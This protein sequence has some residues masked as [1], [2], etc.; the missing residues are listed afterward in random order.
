MKKL[1]ITFHHRRFLRNI[2]IYTL[3]CSL[4]GFVVGVVVG[5]LTVNVEASCEPIF[6]TR[7]VIDEPEIYLVTEEVETERSA[8]GV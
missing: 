1:Y 2:I 7:Q 8:L 5:K 6:T 3:L 4:I